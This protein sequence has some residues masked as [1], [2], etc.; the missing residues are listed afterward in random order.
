MAQN[1]D[2]HKAGTTFPLSRKMA[3]KIPQPRF[4][5]VVSWLFTLIGPDDR[6]NMTRI[7]KQVLPAP[8]FTA[9]A[10]LIR[11]AIGN[12]WA[13]LTRRIPELG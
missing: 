12:D 8:A 1:A 2:P 7:W 6:E 3:Q 13:E 9:I 11:K 10:E 4:P 5:E